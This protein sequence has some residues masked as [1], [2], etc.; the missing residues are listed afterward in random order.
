VSIAALVAAALATPWRNDVDLG[1]DPE[2]YTAN[3]DRCRGDQEPCVRCGKPVDGPLYASYTTG[4]YW[5]PKELID[6]YPTEGDAVPPEFQPLVDKYGYGLGVWP[7]GPDC[8]K[9][10]P[11]IV[12]DLNEL[13]KGIVARDTEAAN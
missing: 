4:G 8:A 2:K 13:A 1:Y 10:A 3:K 9:Y 11:E 6:V 12:G 5:I 7:I